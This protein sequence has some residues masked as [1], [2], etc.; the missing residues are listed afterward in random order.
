MGIG[1]LIGW[2][3]CGL[4]VGLIARMIVPGRQSMGLLLTT[5]MGIAGALV[6]GFLYSMIWGR[7][8]GPGSTQDNWYGWLVSILGASLLVWLSTKMTSRTRL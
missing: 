4:I 3:V 1:N 7:A 8:D 5:V 2:V 6:G